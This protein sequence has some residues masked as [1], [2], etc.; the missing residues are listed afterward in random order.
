MAVLVA[1]SIV[2]PLCAAAES[3]LSVSLGGE[4]TTG[5]YGTGTET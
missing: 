5:S 3:N 2:A 1:V 4:Y